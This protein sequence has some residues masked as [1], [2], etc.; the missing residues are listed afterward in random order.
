MAP[1]SGIHEPL[2]E[3]GDMITAGDPIGKIHNIE[4]PE[5]EPVLVTAMTDGMLMGRRSNPRTMQGECLATIVRP[6]EIEC[7]GLD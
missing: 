5:Q 3:L 7:H 2:L 1:T 4:H 6:V